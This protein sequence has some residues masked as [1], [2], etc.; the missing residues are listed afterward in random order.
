MIK[1]LSIRDLRGI[2]SGKICNLAPITFLIGPNN[3]GK[4]TILD[5]LL[6]SANRDPSAAVNSV[7]QRRHD[8]QFPQRWLIYTLR[9]E[10]AKWARIIISLGS[11][12]TRVVDVFRQQ[13]TPDAGFLVSSAAVRDMGEGENL[14]APSSQP[15]KRVEPLSDVAD[16]RLIEPMSRNGQRPLHELYTEV[17]ERGLRKDAKSLLAELIPS[18]DD[19]QIL[20][21]QN[22]PIVYLVY[23]S[24]AQP[25]SLA[26]DGVRVLLREAL[27]LAA[28]PN[29]LILLEEP[30]V[31][32][33]P[34]AIRQLAK[35]IVAASHRKTQVIAATHSLELI[36]ALISNLPEQE[37]S[38]LAIIRVQ[39][40]EGELSAVRLSGEEAAL[41]RTQI[42]NDLR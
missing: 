10:Q 18:L 15:V 40:K 6:I 1:H 25:V 11:G 3:S 14:P 7:L 37:L 28:P 17:A 26:G 19:I 13:P 9:G 29:S 27:E 34:A 42:E 21:Q 30:E 38:S 32:M 39:L 31:H 24:G 41:A 36:D 33:H 16:V 4:S 20:T 2:K 35:A 12:K 22:Q 8:L 23:D 5:A